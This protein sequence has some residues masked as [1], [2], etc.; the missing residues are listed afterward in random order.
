MQGLQIKG[1]HCNL[2]V[3]ILKTTGEFE[4][5]LLLQNVT[6]LRVLEA[7]PPNP[8]TIGRVLIHFMGRG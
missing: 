6:V 1:L 7:N 8:Q 4:Y 2:E 5:N 3:E